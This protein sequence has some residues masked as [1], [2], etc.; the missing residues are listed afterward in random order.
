MLTAPY[1]QRVQR[2]YLVHSKHVAQILNGIRALVTSM[3]DMSGGRKIEAGSFP[4]HQML[5]VGGLKLNIVRIAVQ[6]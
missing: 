3:S 4:L 1:A 6:T 5:A 2:K